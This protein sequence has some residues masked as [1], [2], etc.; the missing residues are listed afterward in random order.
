[1]EILSRMC[2]NEKGCAVEFLSFS[3]ISK[4]NG[5][6][7]QN[8]SRVHGQSHTPRNY[9]RRRENGSSRKDSK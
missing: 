7:K 4:K 1:M 8:E 9:P 5:F 2:M 3:L 6:S